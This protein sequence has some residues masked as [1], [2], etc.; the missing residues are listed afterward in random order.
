MDNFEILAGD[1]E[2]NLGSITYGHRKEFPLM[3]SHDLRH[4]WYFWEHKWI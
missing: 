3:I 2:A 4:Q 1:L